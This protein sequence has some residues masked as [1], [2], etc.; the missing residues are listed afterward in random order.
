MSDNSIFSPASPKQEM[1]IQSA[2]NVQIVVIGGAAGS[3]KRYVLQLI[4]LLLADDPKTKCLMFRRTT[5]QI[6]GPGGIWDTAKGIYNKLPKEYRPRIRDKAMEAI[7]PDLEDPSMDGM[8]VKYSHMQNENDKFN[9]QGLQLTMIGV[10]EACQFEWSQLEY[11]M[12]RLRSE[13]KHFSR[14]IMSCNPDSDH[15]IK[16]LISWGLS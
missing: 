15:K 9:I 2:M 14:M 3:G 4:P 5:P 11:M 7:F 6:T 8:T 1:M 16:A 12:S 13:S 10:D